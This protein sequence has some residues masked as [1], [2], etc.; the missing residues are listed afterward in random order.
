LSTRL[1]LEPTR[2]QPVDEACR[3]LF[4]EHAKSADDATLLMADF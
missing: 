3:A 4:A 2:A 1:S